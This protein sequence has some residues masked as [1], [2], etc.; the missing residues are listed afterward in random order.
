MRFFRFC[1]PDRRLSVF[2]A[3]V[4][5]GR[6]TT[7]SGDVPGA[8]PT[9]AT[10]PVDAFFRGADGFI[11]LQPV[12]W[13]SLM[14][15]GAVVYG[16]NTGNDQP[17][18]WVPPERFRATLTFNAPDWA[19]WRENYATF[20]VTGVSRQWRFD[21]NADLVTPPDGYAL[22]DMAL[23]TATRVGDW[24]VKFAVTASNV[25]NSRYGNTPVSCDISPTGRDVKRC[26]AS[27]CSS[28]P[29]TPR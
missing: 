24:T 12:N 17:L 10:Q 11:E 15:Q 20:G 14:L 5:R 7:V 21:P 18:T 26:F 6:D 28:T 16:D 3:G 22:V 13:V 27:L 8:T 2:C 4:A 25:L 29:Q 9:F 1:E 23:G 19:G